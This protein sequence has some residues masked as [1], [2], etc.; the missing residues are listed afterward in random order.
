MVEQATECLKGTSTL[1]RKPVDDAEL[2]QIRRK[3]LEG[4]GQGARA[5]HIPI[6]QRQPLLGRADQANY[7]PASSR[8]ASAGAQ[9]FWPP[10]CS[11]ED[12]AGG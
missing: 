7:T 9:Y 10:H 12:G 1:A 4:G 3:L 6:G 11:Q 8:R 5:E 2:G